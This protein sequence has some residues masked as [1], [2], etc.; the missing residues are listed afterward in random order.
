MCTFIIN[1]LLNHPPEKGTSLFF[2]N[3][4]PSSHLLQDF[5][6]VLKILLMQGVVPNT[7][8]GQTE[9]E[10]GAEKDLLKDYCKEMGGLCPKTPS[11]PEFMPSIKKKK[12][13][14]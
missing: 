12:N 2:P 7:Q 10:F 6:K 14:I 13:F 3:M 4:S 11:S 8:W 9:M 5:W 1:I